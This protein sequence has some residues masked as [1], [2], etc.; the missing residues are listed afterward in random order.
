MEAT[1]LIRD[2]LANAKRVADK[3]IDGLNEDELNWQPKPGANSIGLIL[4]HMF[5]SEDSF[6]QYLIQKKSPIWT[7]DKWCEKLCKPPT[8]SGSHYNAEQIDTF[9][10]PRIEDLM[11]YGKAVRE[12]TL[13]FVDRLTPEKL[14]AAVE[15]PPIPH[16]P[17][18]GTPPRRPFEPF[19]GS[20]L[21]MTVT[22]QAQHAG[23]ISYL[24]GLQRGLDK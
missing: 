8:D 19:V 7:S 17:G 16:T 10:V 6:V 14:D 5:R 12:K 13:E 20:L 15:L 23:E 9:K 18:Q 2:G 11:A 1:Q 3:T 24:R 21:I 22:H 4:F